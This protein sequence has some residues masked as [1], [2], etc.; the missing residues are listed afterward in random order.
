MPEKEKLYHE[1]ARL[2]ETVKF[3]W[4][5]VDSKQLSG[6][7]RAAM[8]THIEACIADLKALMERL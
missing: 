8:R 7:Q 3:E 1:L 4:Q 6:S 5:D 2:R